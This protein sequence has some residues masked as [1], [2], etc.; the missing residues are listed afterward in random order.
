MSSRNSRCVFELTLDDHGGDGKFIRDCNQIVPVGSHRPDFIDRSQEFRGKCPAGGL[1][2]GEMQFIDG[3]PACGRETGNIADGA[4][5]TESIPGT[6]VRQLSVVAHVDVHF[7]V[8]MAAKRAN[9]VRAR[10]EGKVIAG[11]KALC[12]NKV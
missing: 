11:S 12:Q 2:T 6:G 4:G 7:I 10:S 3:C 9:P 8:M 1:P 5:K